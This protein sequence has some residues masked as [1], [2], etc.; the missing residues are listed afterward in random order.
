M[1]QL[2]LGNFCLQVVNLGSIQLSPEELGVSTSMINVHL[3][4]KLTKGAKLE[5]KFVWP[6][7]QSVSFMPKL[8]RK[9]KQAS[10]VENLAVVL[11]LNPL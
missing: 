2:A 1:N 7:T 8:Y 5:T 10:L 11:V 4:K 3:P 9:S 6:N